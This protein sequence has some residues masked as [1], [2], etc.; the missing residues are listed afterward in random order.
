MPREE[1]LR[2]EFAQ[3]SEAAQK[4]IV[5]TQKKIGD[6]TLQAGQEFLKIV[7]EMGREFTSCVAA[8]AELSLR[9]SKRLS[10]ARSIP[11]AMAAYQEWLHEEMVRRSQD[12]SRLVTTSQK[13]INTSTRIFSNGWPAAD[14]NWPRVG[15]ST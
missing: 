6:V 9:L 7:E 5:N 15:V 3:A 2:D 12:A 13:F 8:E 10:E 14:M 11:D 4:Q 1:S